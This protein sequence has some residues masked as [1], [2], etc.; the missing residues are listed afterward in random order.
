MG[1]NNRQRRAAKARRKTSRG[2]RPP[3]PRLPFVSQAAPARS[4]SPPLTLPA[5]S[6][7]A[8]RPTVDDLLDEVSGDPRGLLRV[9]NGSLVA[10]LAQRNAD[11]VR[12]ALARRLV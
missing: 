4:S 10:D 6:S 3:Q 1:K 5:E 11:T 12:G 8:A 9:I 7:A 2:R